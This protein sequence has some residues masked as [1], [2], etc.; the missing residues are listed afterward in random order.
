MSAPPSPEL[1]M[2]VGTGFWASKTLL[3]A[4]ELEL[5]TV[6]GD[7]HLLAAE[8]GDR[9]GL[10]PRSRTDFLDALV[11]LGLLARDGDG[12]SSRYTNT[13]DTALFL[14]KRRPTY[15]GGLL[16]M[17]N[18][19]L[20]AFW[21]NLTKALRTGEPQN[22]AAVGED[23]FAALYSNEDRLEL[24]LRAMQGAQ[25]G[26]LMALVQCIDLS[27]ASVL[28]DVGGANGTL[29]AIAVQHFPNLRAISFDLAPV[30]PV[31]QR[32]L[33]AMGVDDRVTTL[34]GDFF[35]D[36]LP[37][38]D[39]ITMGNILH[40]W[41][42]DQ[43]RTL[44]GKAYAALPDGGRFIAIENL[45]DDERRANTFG[46]L[47][48]LNMLIETPGGFDYTPAQFDG[49]CRAA[50]FTRTEVVPLAGPTSA[51]VAYK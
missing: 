2:Q 24:F 30:I 16:E 19:R 42:E 3:S 12:A 21:G 40:D 32:H 27:S 17:A 25:L 23:F 39:V 8:I 5:F 29:S 7:E 44:I 33:K 4:V 41:N 20:Y 31:A 50:G 37:K 22:E 6:L 10:H 18:E 1:I 28:C 47:M 34:A 15:I 36:D 13:A 14:D 26:P 38:A 51:A 48:S 46:L 43:K 49:W 35:A 45:I 11:S 9:L